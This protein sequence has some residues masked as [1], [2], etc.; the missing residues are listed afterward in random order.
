MAKRELSHEAQH[1]VQARGQDDEIAALPDAGHDGEAEA[2]RVRED[3]GQRHAQRVNGDEDGGVDQISASECFFH[4]FSPTFFP[5]IPAGFT[6][7]T[8]M[9]MRNT[10]VSDRLELM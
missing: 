4:T 6:S 1:E 10:K 3:D 5:S 2:A 9:R 7:S 8:S